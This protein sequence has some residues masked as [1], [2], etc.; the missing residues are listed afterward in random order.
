MKTLEKLVTFARE[1]SENGMVSVSLDAN[2][3]YWLVLAHT[4]GTAPRT[5]HAVGYVKCPVKYIRNRITEYF[6]TR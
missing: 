6:A 3:V 5:L 4:D 1:V 2:G